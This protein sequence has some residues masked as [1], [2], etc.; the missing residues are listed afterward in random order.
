MEELSQKE[1]LYYKMIDLKL[2]LGYRPTQYGIDLIDRFMDTNIIVGSIPFKTPGLR[3]MAF[4]GDAPAPDSIVLN[5][6]RN[7]LERNFDCGHETVHLSLH[8]H[9]EQKTFNCFDDEV[10]A[11]QD[12]FLEWQ[13]NEGSAELLIPHTVFLPLVKIYFGTKPDYNSVEKFKCMASKL[14]GVPPAVIKYR[15][16]SLKYEIVQ[17]YAGVKI[18]D[19]QILSKRQ[20]EK[21]GIYITSFNRIKP[22]EYLDMEKYAKMKNRSGGNQN[23]F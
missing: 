10:H 8:R 17:Y 1:L 5:S 6:R 14:F 11:D 19:M 9:L 16:E 12:P 22:G 13:A 20:Q 2:F 18:L 7:E 4:V 21:R 23:G 15:L 3:G